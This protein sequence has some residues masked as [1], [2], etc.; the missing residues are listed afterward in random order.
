MKLFRLLFKTS[1][2]NLIL[3]AIAGLFSGSSSVGVIATM[4]KTLRSPTLPDSDVAWQFFG[5][6]CVFLVSTILSQALMSRLAQKSAYRLQVRLSQSII[7]SPLNQLENIGNHRLLASLTGDVQSIASSSLVFSNVCISIAKLVGCLI[8]LAWLDLRLFGLVLIFL[9]FFA[10]TQNKLRAKGKSFFKLSREQK[11]IMFKHFRTMTNG[12]KE[13]KLHQERREAF[14]VEDFQQAAKTFRGYR[15]QAT[16]LFAVA[17]GSG[18]FFIFVSIG[19]LIWFVSPRLDFSFALLSDY[20]LTIIFMIAPIRILLNTLPNLTKANIALD[21]IEYLGLSLSDEVTESA[22]TQSPY[23]QPKW[24]SLKLEGVS[25]SYRRGKDDNPFVLGSINLKFTPG[26]I[27]FIIGGNGSG[28]STLVKLITGLYTPEE[29]RI[30]F[31]N[32][33]ITDSNREWYRQ[34]FSVVFADFYLFDRFLGLENSDLEGKIQ[35]YLTQLQIDH[36][37][38]VDRGVLSTTALSQGQRKRLALLTAYLEDR[39]IYIFDEWAADQDP[40]FKKIF[41]DELLPEL[42]QRGKTVIVISHDD[43]YFDRGDRIIKLDYGKV[44]ET[45]I[46]EIAKIEK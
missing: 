12:I 14:M 45:K 31:D 17:N 44:V 41:Y 8:Y 3:A 9:T 4:N 16:D 29:G 35:H 11:D 38:T 18:L 15:I 24:T 7:A 39:P 33:Y 13:L 19:F 27:V 21:K 6:C 5:L 46:T 10:L 23:Y 40:V 32:Q 20:V 43:R 2:V 34:H 30:E 25:H 22:L 42:K 26:E 37:V 28:K 36:K 1:K